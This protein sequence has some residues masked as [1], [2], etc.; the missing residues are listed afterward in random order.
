MKLILSLDVERESFVFVVFFLKTELHLVFLALLHLCV[1]LCPR[2]NQTYPFAENREQTEAEERDSEV[3]QHENEK[4]LS[5]LVTRVLRQIEAGI[6]NYSAN[7][8]SK[9]KSEQLAPQFRVYPEQWSD[10]V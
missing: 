9:K 6:G 10:V 2:D 7:G 4:E 8:G 5:G 3:R 1:E